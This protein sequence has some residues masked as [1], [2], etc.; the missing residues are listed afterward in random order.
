MALI[1]ISLYRLDYVSL[2]E[3]EKDRVVVVESYVGG[4]LCRKFPASQT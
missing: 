3:G 2:R 4:R 1:R